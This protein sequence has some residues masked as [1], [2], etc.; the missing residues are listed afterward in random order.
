[1]TVEDGIMKASLEGAVGKARIVE[2]RK[3]TRMRTRLLKLA[4]LVIFVF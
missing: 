4:M 3:L 1:M 2:I